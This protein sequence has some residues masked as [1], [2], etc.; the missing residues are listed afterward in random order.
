MSEVDAKIK[1]AKKKIIRTTKF[2]KARTII[3]LFKKTYGYSFNKKENECYDTFLNL[4]NDKISIL[5][6]EIINAT[7]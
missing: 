3:E 7:V 5:D 1:R 2:K 6:D 4:I